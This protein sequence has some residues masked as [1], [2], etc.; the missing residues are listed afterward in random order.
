[1]RYLIS[2]VLS[3]AAVLAYVFG[4]R[5]ALFGAPLLGSALLLIGLALEITTWC[6]LLRVPSGS[7]SGA[8]T[9]R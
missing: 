7:S 3:S 6:R 4:P 5:P 8:A 9:A 2:T 1:M